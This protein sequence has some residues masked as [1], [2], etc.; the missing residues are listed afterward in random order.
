MV[1]LLDLVSHLQNK[2]HFKMIAFQL[3]NKNKNEVELTLIEIT[4]RIYL[5]L[6]GF[7]ILV[8]SIFGV[9]I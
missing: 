9:V 2:N 1:S 7:I 6:T 8:F 5:V 3:K 4:F